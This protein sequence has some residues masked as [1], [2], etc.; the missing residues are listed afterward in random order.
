MPPFLNQTQIKQPHNYFL[1]S[2]F[3]TEGIWHML[4]IMVVL[5]NFKSFQKNMK[6]DRLHRRISLSFLT[7]TLAGKKK[8]NAFKIP[9]EF[10]PQMLYTSYQPNIDKK[11][12]RR[13][14]SQKKGGGIQKTENWN[15]RE[16]KLFFYDSEGKLQNDR[17][18]AEQRSNQSMA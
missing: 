17:C 14:R 12:L 9:K 11:H 1:D 6:Y 4:N 15:R 10:W 18:T 3:A 5:F 13:I 8:T 7:T 16:I 2:F